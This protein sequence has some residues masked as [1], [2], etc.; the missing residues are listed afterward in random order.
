MNKNRIFF[1]GLT[2]FNQL[3]ISRKDIHWDFMN[4]ICYKMQAIQTFWLWLL[5]LHV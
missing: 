2:F 5:P 3:E 1:Y 4:I